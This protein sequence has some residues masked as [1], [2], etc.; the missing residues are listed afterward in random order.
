MEEIFEHY[1]ALMIALENQ[2]KCDHILTLM[3]VVRDKIIE[4]DE[5]E[6]SVVTN[7]ENAL[8][9]SRKGHR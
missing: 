4:L 8:F 9:D 5:L 1:N 2:G 3:E 7:D 6:D